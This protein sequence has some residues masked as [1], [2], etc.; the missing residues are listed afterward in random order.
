MLL[1]GSGLLQIVK[2]LAMRPRPL[3]DPLL[4]ALIADGVK[5]QVWG[6]WNKLDVPL[7]RYAQQLHVIGMTLIS[8]CMLLMVMTQITYS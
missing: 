8:L 7:T 3:K 2:S 1:L 5:S 4:G 6:L